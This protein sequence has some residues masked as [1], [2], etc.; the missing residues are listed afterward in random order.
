MEPRKTRKDADGRGAGRLFL[1]S[2][3]KRE[4]EAGEGGSAAPLLKRLSEHLVSR[5]GSRGAVL[6][7]EP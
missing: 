6:P 4:G 2:P 1:L 5:S 7:A 3:A